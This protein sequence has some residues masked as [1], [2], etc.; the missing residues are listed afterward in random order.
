MIFKSVRHVITI[1][2]PCSNGIAFLHE[3][4]HEPGC[5]GDHAAGRKRLIPLEQTV[6]FFFYQIKFVI[7]R[8]R[9]DLHLYTFPLFIRLRIDQHRHDFQIGIKV[10][11]F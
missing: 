1:R 6:G 2:H 10:I 11:L 9:K 8:V 4:L 3:L 5:Q 7:I